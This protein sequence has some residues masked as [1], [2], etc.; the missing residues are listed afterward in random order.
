MQLIVQFKPPAR[1]ITLVPEG[2]N[3]LEQ[4]KRKEEPSKKKL[5]ILKEQKQCKIVVAS[6]LDLLFMRVI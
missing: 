2:I 4:E 5:S 3:V 1:L 6:W